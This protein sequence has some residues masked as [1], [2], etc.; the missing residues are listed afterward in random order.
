MP[1]LLLSQSRVRQIHVLETLVSLQEHTQ[2]IHVLGLLFAEAPIEDAAAFS[3]WLS[4]FI[5]NLW[6]ECVI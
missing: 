5:L 1:K 6:K 4:V 2:L 3:C